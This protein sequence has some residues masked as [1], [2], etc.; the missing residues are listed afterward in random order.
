[1]SLEYLLVKSEALPD[2]YRSVV[3]AKKLLSSGEASSSAEA[4]RMAGISRSAFYKYKDMVFQ[5][6]KAVRDEVITVHAVLTDKPG[7]L[8]ALLAVFF[9]AKANILTVNQNIPVGG[10]A[11]VSISARTDSM[12][13]SKEELFS[14][15][16]DLSGVKTIDNIS[17]V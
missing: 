9:E 4:A 1:M 7:V 16:Q 15:L 6:E 3:Y 10:V 13:I 14:M 5:Y 11:S 2:V 8:S 17:G 12:S